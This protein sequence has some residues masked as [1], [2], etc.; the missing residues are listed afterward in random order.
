MPLSQ[1]TGS[2]TANYS[3]AGT[4]A[5]FIVVGLSYFLLLLILAGP[6]YFGH[7]IK[8][9]DLS[10]QEIIAPR[11]IFV[12]DEEKTQEKQE[13]ARHDVL[14]V[15]KRDSRKSSEI[16]EKIRAEIEKIQ[17]L[18]KESIL[19]PALAGI[20]SA[21]EQ[22][23]MLQLSDDDYKILLE[24]LAESVPSAE[25]DHKKKLDALSWK[26]LAFTE[27]QRRAEAE[28]LRI[29]KQK[30]R[31]KKG[32]S[33]K[34]QAK[35][36]AA[37]E[38]KDAKAAEA[39]E[40]ISNEKLV[41]MLERSRRNYEGRKKNLDSSLIRIAVLLKPEESEVFCQQVSDSLKRLLT[42]LSLQPYVDRHEW[43]EELFEF[44]PDSINSDLRRKTAVFVAS[45]LEPNVVVDQAE[46]EEK[47]KQAVEAVAPV[48][49][50]IEVGAVIVQKG[51]T[52]KEEQVRTLEKLGITEVS[53][54]GLASV[55]AISLFAAYLLFGVYLF[56]YESK[57][58]FSPSALAL[59]ST[60]AITT[61][62]LAIFVAPQLPA[63]VPLPAATLIL[64]VTYGKRLTAILTA[65][66]LLFLNAGELVVGADLV[67]LGAA[68]A[69]ALGANV[70]R[71][72]DLMITG[73]L[74]GFMQMLGYASAVLIAGNQ[75]QI[76]TMPALLPMEM[77]GGLV[78]AIAAIGSLPFL[79][80]IFGILTPYRI[81]ELAEPDQPLM[82]Q[83]EENAPGT[84]QHSLAVANLAEGG[85]RAIGANVNLVHTGAMYHDIG[86]MVTPRYFIENQLGDKNPHDFIPPEESR[87]KV[88]AHV[89]NGLLLAQKY[90]LPKAVQAFIPEHQG[91]T[92]I[93]YFY[94]KA[95]IR[96]GAENVDPN[97][98][99]YPGPKP[100]TKESAIVMLADVSEA[101]THSMKEPTMEDVENAISAVF[102]NRWDDGQFSESELT[103]EELEKVKRGFVRV[104]RTLHHDR[105]KY[106]S[107]T[108]GRMPVAPEKRPPAGELGP[109][110][111]PN[112]KNGDSG[113]PEPEDANATVQ[114]AASEWDC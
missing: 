93:A 65:L 88:L 59:M 69:M 91:T 109:A 100:Q 103:I 10:E 75:N 52:I 58:F 27:T 20:L 90:G 44:L 26:L 30:P 46:T 50:E 62:G 34:I 86:K 25:L 63:F 39:P 8:A 49:K 84:Y 104:W 99:R 97:N 33:S 13:I 29:E 67:A 89:T 35:D 5:W 16:F 111:T 9:G 98:Y 74:L 54:P 82:R 2:K 7:H 78:S 42:N 23:Y 45:R 31:Q 40:F 73:L 17:L 114:K 79:E 87:S 94:H 77:L 55:L 19:I 6:H 28:H 37:K 53:D 21:D 36:K 81:A 66:I 101:V 106:P 95:C 113:A 80:N 76:A 72:R 48:I 38:T 83:L 43:E 56:T 1:N 60:V 22:I 4:F 105:L 18:R 102:Q 32:R 41:E 68:S 11:K 24:R 112:Q 96:D 108:T 71:R 64:A 3:I 57:L 51:E 110:E 92:V 47:V 70:K 107:T 12:V 14:P 61:C 85:A 15:L